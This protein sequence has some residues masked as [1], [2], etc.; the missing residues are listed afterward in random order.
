LSSDEET[1]TDVFEDSDAVAG[2][3]RRND[4]A[5]ESRGLFRQTWLILSCLLFIAAAVLLTLSRTDAAFVAAALAVSAW[6]WNMRLKLKRQY[7]I[8]KHNRER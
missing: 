4:S 3:A 6:F 8:R 2:E 7:G 1:E 5:P